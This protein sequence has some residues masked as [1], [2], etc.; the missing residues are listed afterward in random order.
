MANPT[1]K[2][3]FK[4][5]ESGNPNGRPKGTRHKL[6]EDFIAALAADFETNGVKAIAAVRKKNKSAYLK[7]VAG[8]VPKEIEA[9]V[10][11]DFNIRWQQK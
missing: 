6:S 11:G 9:T 7:L 4:P 8:L 1:G 3:G 5:G 2:G 10:E